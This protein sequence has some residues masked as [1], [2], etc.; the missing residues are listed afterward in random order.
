M[1][2][3]I[4]IILGFFISLGLLCWFLYRGLQR[5]TF[6]YDVAFL[7]DRFDRQVLESARSKSKKE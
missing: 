1:E 6:D 2:F 5:D 7:W 4:V 3:F